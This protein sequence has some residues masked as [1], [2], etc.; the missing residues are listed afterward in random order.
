MNTHFTSDSHL[1]H[2]RVLNYQQNRKELFYDSSAE[3][4][5][6][7]KGEIA[8]P[9]EMEHMSRHFIV[10]WNACVKPEDTVY[11]LGDVHFGNAE[12]IKELSRLNGRKI[13]IRGN[14]DGK[15]TD[16]LTKSGVFEAI[17]DYLFIELPSPATGVKVGIALFHYPILVWDKSDR[18][19]FHLHGH[20]HG[21]GTKMSCYDQTLR[22][23]DVG[24]DTH[25]E[26]R[27]YSWGEVY[28]TLI[29]RTGL[30]DR[31]V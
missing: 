2:K 31:H 25:P 17:H 10:S 1:W 16:R 15:R 4:K 27:P 29:K 18:G 19:S 11:I 30:I 5:R 12:Q 23:M 26:F 14:H 3:H 8:N 13:L 24:V 22:R 20:M 9:E 21:D 6:D 28:D 7:E